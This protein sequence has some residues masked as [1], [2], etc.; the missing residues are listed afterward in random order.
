MPLNDSLETKTLNND[1][2]IDVFEMKERKRKEMCFVV[3]IQNYSIKI[4]YMRLPD[5]C[6]TVPYSNVRKTS[7]NA[8]DFMGI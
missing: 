3:G 1:L 2:S 5:K 4:K 7:K 8:Y 6:V